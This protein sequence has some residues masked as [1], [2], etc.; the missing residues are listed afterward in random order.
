MPLTGR[1][2]RGAGSGYAHQPATYRRDLRD[3]AGATREIAEHT[4]ATRG[5]AV[6]VAN[7]DHAP[8]LCYGDLRDWAAIAA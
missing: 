4:L 6:E 8:E 7:V 1:S 5:A 3:G 2:A